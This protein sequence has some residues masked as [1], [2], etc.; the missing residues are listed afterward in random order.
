MK[1]NK[2]IFGISCLIFIFVIAMSFNSSHSLKDE[3]GI[4]LKKPKEFIVELSNISEGEAVETAEIVDNFVIEDMTIKNGSFVFRNPGDF[5]TY[6]FNV[7][8]GGDINASLSKLETPSFTCTSLDEKE[9]VA[10]DVCSKISVDLS[11]KNI[12]N[13]MVE[14]G[15]SLAACTSTAI[16]LSVIYNN[17]EDTLDNV[18]VRVDNVSLALGYEKDNTAKRTVG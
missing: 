16:T 11:Y 7:I 3:N 17:G 1:H 2:V 6:T 14:K 15:D 5:V 18:N 12:P 9:D 8:N 10:L 13:K 4:N